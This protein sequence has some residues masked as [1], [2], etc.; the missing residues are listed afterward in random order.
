MVRAGQKR[1]RCAASC[2]CGLIWSHFIN[3]ASWVNFTELFKVETSLLDRHELLSWS[4]TGIT[5]S[6]KAKD[7]IRH[8]ENIIDFRHTVQYFCWFHTTIRRSSKPKSRHSDKMRI[9]VKPLTFQNVRHL[10]FCHCWPQWQPS[11]WA[12]VQFWLVARGFPAFY[13][14]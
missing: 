7:V 9:K 13:W 6:V 4:I 10:L 3:G 11:L 1:G 8:R 14:S 5:V 2:D 12:G